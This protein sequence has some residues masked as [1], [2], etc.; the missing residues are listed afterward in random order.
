M[1]TGTLLRLHRALDELYW[2]EWGLLNRWKGGHW[3]SGVLVLF[4]MALISCWFLT[5]HNGLLLEIIVIGWHFVNDSLDNIRGGIQA[6]EK[7]VHQFVAFYCVPCFLGKHL[8][9]ANILVNVGKAE[10]EVIKGCLGNFLLSGVCKLHF[11]SH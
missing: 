6:F 2:K 11:E 5:H 3:N 1:G 10:G 9:V 8:E 4:F 7:H